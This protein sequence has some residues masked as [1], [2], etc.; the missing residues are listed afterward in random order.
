MTSLAIVHQDRTTGPSPLFW[1]M[2]A[3]VCALVLLATVAVSHAV[4]R[5]GNEALLARSCAQRPEAMFFN[6]TTGRTAL[7]CLVEGKFGI[8]VL[9][10]LGNEVT[11]FIKNKMQTFEQVEQYLKNAGYGWIQ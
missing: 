3:L 8:Y 4:E 7:V 10:E 1:L 9:D 6:P 5:H 2:L 11:A